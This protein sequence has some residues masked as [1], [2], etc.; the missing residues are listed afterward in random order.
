V[1]SS[2]LDQIPGIGPKKRQALLREFG[3]VRKLLA[4]TD[5]DIAAVAGIGQKDVERIRAHFK[6]KEIGLTA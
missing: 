2:A 4:A 1:I 6:V 5:E 3:S